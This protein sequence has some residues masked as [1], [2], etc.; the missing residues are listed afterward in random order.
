MLGTYRL[1]YASDTRKQT[2]GNMRGRIWD[3]TFRL[4]AHEYRNNVCG[5]AERDRPQ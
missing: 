4:G 2:D 1:E 3:E 5:V